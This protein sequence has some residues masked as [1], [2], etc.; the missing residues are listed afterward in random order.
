MA[1]RIKSLFRKINRATA[2]QK[3]ILKSLS[4]PLILRRKGTES[5]KGFH[6]FPIF[7]FL[8]FQVEGEFERDV[9]LEVG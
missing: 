2:L 6:G 4:K 9:I 1:I 7:L 3:P 5:P 8:N